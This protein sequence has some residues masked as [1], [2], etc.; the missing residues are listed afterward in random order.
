MAFK[1]PKIEIILNKVVKATWPSLDYTGVARA[2][3]AIGTLPAP[4]AAASLSSSVPAGKIPAPYASSRNWDKIG[5]EIEQEL[6]SEKPEGEEALQ[7][8]FK[9][10]LTANAHFCIFALLP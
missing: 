7:K 10:S 6:N 3:P 1:V 4:E 2:P 9:V 5:G 8:L